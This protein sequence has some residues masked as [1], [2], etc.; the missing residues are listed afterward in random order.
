MENRIEHLLKLWYVDQIQY[1]LCVGTVKLSILF[2]YLRISSNLRLPVFLTVA[3]VACVTISTTLVVIFQCIPVSFMWNKKDRSGKCVDMTIFWTAGAALNIV[4][5]FI[6]YVMPMRTLW[7]VQLPTRERIGIVAVFAAGAMVVV[8]GI[9]R[10]HSLTIISQSEDITWVN[11]PSMLWSTSEL[12]LGVVCACLP[13]LKQLFGRVFGFTKSVSCS[14]DGY[15]AHTGDTAGTD[16]SK[17]YK[18]GSRTV[19]PLSVTDTVL[20]QMCGY[21]PNTGVDTTVDTRDFERDS[22]KEILCENGAADGKIIKTTDVTVTSRN[23]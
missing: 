21:G 18:K 15:G 17:P 3:F 4:G 2:F 13:A 19:Y 9:I 22:S 16:G 14:D 1:V 23:P 11:S 8:I 5:D 6:I 7:H 10:L 12:E 20:V